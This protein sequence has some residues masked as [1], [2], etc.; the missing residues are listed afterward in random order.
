MYRPRAQTAQLIWDDL[1]KHGASDGDA[2]RARTGLS[3]MQFQY[4]KGFL[5]DE[6]QT[7]YRQPLIWSPRRGVYELTSTEGDWMDYLMAWRLKSILTQLRRTEQ[8]AIAG[9][10]K[11]GTRKAATRVAIAGITAARQMVEALIP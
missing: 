11:F 7:K 3:Q 10:M 8:T 1:L 4:G 6:L 2:I 9:G 5:L